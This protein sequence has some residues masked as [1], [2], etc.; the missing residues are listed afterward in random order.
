MWT[1]W[2]DEE[3]GINWE[4]ETDIHTP[5]GVKWR[6]IKHRK[7]SSMLCD[8]LERWDWEG[9]GMEAQEG[10]NICVHIADSLCCT[11]ETNITL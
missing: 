9:D 1:Q 10:G 8:D 11:S 6:A 5:P 2:G 3:G 7:L 4:I